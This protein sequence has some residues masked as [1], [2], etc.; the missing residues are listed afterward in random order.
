MGS[1]YLKR[2][3]ATPLY[4]LLHL[5]R[6]CN[7]D[8][9][10]VAFTPNFTAKVM[11]MMISTILLL[12]TF[13]HDPSEAIHHLEKMQLVTCPGF[14]GY[15]SESYPGGVCTVVCAFGR[16]N[17]PECQ[18]DGTWTDI[19]RCIEHEPGKE[20]QIPGFCPGIPGYC[21]DDRSGGVCEFDCLIGPD[22]RSFCTPD[23]TWEPYPTCDGDIRD[24]RDGCDGCPGEFGGARNRTAEAAGGGKKKQGGSR[25][26]AQPARAAAARPSGRPQASSAARPAKRPANN[27]R[28]Q[29]QKKNQG[30]RRRNQ[31]A[32]RPSGNR[33]RPTAQASR[34]QRPK[35]PQAPRQQ[36]SPVAPRQQPKQQRPPQQALVKS[37]PKAQKTS[38]GGASNKAS[39]GRTCPGGSLEMCI[40]VC[41]SFS[42]RIFGACVG[43]CAKRCPSKK[44]KNL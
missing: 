6:N 33:K 29:G 12:F 3:Q 18:A 22:I 11:A 36:A 17:V 41:P 21:S 15:C 35:S 30:S 2:N 13:L 20:T 7:F 37:Q 10:S 28:G 23:G 25:A 32:K 4:S 27:R 40:D 38:S 1:C 24:T 42:A 14:A 16:P 34:P 26:P 31:G 9:S 43:G 8:S 39:G 5:F 44:K 19:P